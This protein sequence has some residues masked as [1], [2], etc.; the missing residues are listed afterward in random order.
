MP[1]WK[2]R[3]CAAALCLLAGGAALANLADYTSK[4]DPEYR[5][6]KDGETKAGDVKIVNIKLRSQSWQGAPWDHNIQVFLPDTAKY[7]KTAFL[8]ITGG[9]PGPAETVLFAS[10]APRLG[11]PLAILWNIPNQ[12]LFDG[13]LEDDLIAHTFEEY[14][15]SGDENWPLLF[16]MVKSAIRAMDALQDVSRKEWAAPVED[17][18]VSGASKRGWT[19]YLTA[20]A[21]RRVRGIAPMVFDNL[22]FRAQMPRQ[23]EL[24]GRYSEQIDDYSR[25][26]LQAKMETERGR[27]LV[28]LVDPWFYRNRLTMPKLLIHGANDRYWATDAVRGY[29]DDLRG[30]KY[31]LNV[32]NAGHGLEDRMRVLNTL[33]AFHQAVAGERAFPRLSARHSAR[34]GRVTVTLRSTMKPREA[35]LWTARAGDLDFRPV[36]WE[37]LSMTA[38]DEL[39]QGETEL[40]KSGGLSVFAEAEFEVDG[41]TFTLSTP[42]SVYGKRPPEKPEKTG[43]E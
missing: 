11:S 7:P 9:N 8:F 40:P 29:W 1:S 30:D 18:V 42:A 20:A 19:T 35:R 2:I 41:Q 15:K 5:Y 39:H 32:P 24:W 36:K 31:L 10:L 22:N 3:S 17:F 14:L 27:K 25:R 6:G 34:N 38:R 26:G 33:A 16:P 12:P 21:D 43:N 4:P 37:P 28:S 13:K 23:L